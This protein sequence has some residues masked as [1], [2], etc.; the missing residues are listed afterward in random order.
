MLRRKHFGIAMLF[1]LS[2]IPVFLWLLG[3]DTT[4]L[5]SSIG[6]FVSALGKAT[7]LS[8]FALYLLMP[9]LSTRHAALEKLFGGLNTVYDLHKS[10]GKKSF[11]L[12]VLHPLL[13]GA[14]RYLNGRGLSELWAW[15]SLLILSG[16]VALIVLCMVTFV[17]IYMHIKHQNWIWV[18]RLFGWLI[19]L[20]FVHAFVARGQLV[21]NKVLM[22][23]FVALGLIGFAA[24][25]YRSVF[26]KYIMKRYNYV[27]SEVNHLTD[28][29]SEIVLKPLNIPMSFAPGQFAFVSFAGD[30]VDTEAHPFSFSNANNGPYVRFTVKAL[31]DDTKTF[32]KLTEGTPAF[33][34]GPYGD[35]SYKNVKNRKQVWI[36]GGIGITPFLSMARSFAGKQH[37]DIRFFYGTESLGEAVFLQEFI[38]IMRHVPE[39]FDVKVVAKNLSGFI[40]P[41]MIK[42]DVEHLD[43]YDY[44]ICGPPAMMQ[45]MKEGLRLAGVPEDQ[46]H[47]EAFSM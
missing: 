44:M 23:Y 29:V 43:K 11:I 16:I 28:T 10:A 37:Y 47:T 39:N 20:F 14:G 34:E 18:H 8:G 36:A 24:F 41:E 30:G 12:I 38:D 4:R 2:V 26:A 40:T 9:V 32:Q 5:T 6:S 21:Q 25:L 13:L 19:P 22:A 27:I 46:I 7:A 33:L 15:S 3:T 31:G 17:S 1:I 45:A 42:K 35:F